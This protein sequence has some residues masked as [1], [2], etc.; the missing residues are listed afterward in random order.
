M[1]PPD[2]FSSLTPSSSLHVLSSCL[3]VGSRGCATDRSAK[4]LMRCCIE[5]LCGHGLDLHISAQH[6]GVCVNNVRAVCKRIVNSSCGDL[7]HKQAQHIKTWCRYTLPCC[8]VSSRCRPSVLLA[9]F[10]P[11]ASRAVARQAPHDSGSEPGSR[12]SSRHFTAWSRAGT[13]DAPSFLTS[14]SSSFAC[15]RLTC[16]RSLS[17]SR[18]EFASSTLS[19]YKILSISSYSL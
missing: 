12:S 17:I 15:S 5:N 4:A 13:L 19:C 9:R 10:T 8:I 11:R 14:L 6:A 7:M 18:R 1:Y 2:I 3:P 16:A